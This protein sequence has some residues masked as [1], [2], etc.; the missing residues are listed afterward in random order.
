[1]A[2][3]AYAA[4]ASGPLRIHPDNPRYFTDSSGQAIYLTGSHT[5]Y[6]LQDSGTIGEPLTHF[7]YDAYLD[8][9]Q[10][11][12]HN[13]MRMWA[14][15]GGV[16][17]KYC[18]PLAYS[19]NGPGTALDGKPKFDLN[20]FDQEYFDR[21]RNRVVAA[22]HRGIYVSIMLF[23]GWS[24]YSHGYGNPWP[25]HPFNKANNIN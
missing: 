6:N 9:L 19:R 12:G 17:D 18:E 13:F 20:Q 21:L 14:W 16:N 25:L 24:I 1:M 22:G 7:D 11:S 15:E 2:G 4:K 10:S 8:L 23:Q 3:Q 5:W